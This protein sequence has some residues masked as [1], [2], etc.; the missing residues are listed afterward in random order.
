MASS[1]NRSTS[2]AYGNPLASQ[3]LGY[4]LILAN[5]D[6]IDFIEINAVGSSPRK[7]VVSYPNHHCLECALIERISDH[8]VRQLCGDDE[9]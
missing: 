9:P 4:M 3:S 8:F 5:R 6:G 1:I 7:S 2:W